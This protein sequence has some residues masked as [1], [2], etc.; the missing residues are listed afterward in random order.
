MTTVHRYGKRPAQHRHRRGRRQFWQFMI[1]GTVFVALVAAKLYSPRH[2]ATL[3]RAISGAMDRNMDVQEVFASVGRTFAGENAPA[4][5]LREVWNAVFL[6][7]DGGT[8]TGQT[9]TETL[10]GLISGNASETL[11]G[12]AAEPPA[13]DVPEIAPQTDSETPETLTRHQWTE[14]FGN[15]TAFASLSEPWPETSG[16]AV[17]PESSVDDARPEGQAS[18]LYTGQNLPQNVGMEQVLLNFDYQSPVHGEMT[19]GFGYRKHP[20]DGVERFHYGVD[21]AAETG[22]DIVCFAD[23]VVTATGESTSFGR[24]CTVEHVGG[25]T[26]LYAHCDRVTATSG[27]TVHKGDKLAEVGATG[28]ATGP[29]LHFALQ[30]EGVYLNPV[31]Y[32][33][34]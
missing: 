5:G 7:S 1:C 24:Y 8:E 9:V 21:I 33:A 10:S 6:P 19:S 15:S 22:T 27:A 30:R 13:G 31:Y 11:S 16:A 34:G 3:R 4:E 12:D 23:G 17:I 28:Q 18:F 20:V 2:A 29:H 32:L 26:T 25:F 14:T